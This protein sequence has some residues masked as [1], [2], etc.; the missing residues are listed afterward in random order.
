[1]MVT[2]NGIAP[3]PL[4]PSAFSNFDTRQLERR[5]DMLLDDFTYRDAVFGPITAAKGFETNYASLE[6]LRN[7]LLFPLYA[8]LVGYGDKASTIHDWL[9]SGQ[10][11]TLADGTSKVLS[12][13][14][15]DDVF[16]RALRAEGIAR[17]RARA[18][19]IGVRIG[20]RRYFNCK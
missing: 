15:A 4:E 10:P 3:T 7:P 19:Y 14:A 9:Y 13:K 2:C 5:L 8:L 1:M 6:A 16:Y 11:V 18:F 20:G 12:R 17:W